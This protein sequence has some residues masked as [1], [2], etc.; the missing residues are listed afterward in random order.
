MTREFGPI[1]GYG[2]D[3]FKKEDHYHNLSLD[4]EHALFGNDLLEHAILLT[5]EDVLLRD[6]RAAHGE[7][8]QFL[9]RA[10]DP[11]GSANSFSIGFWG[12]IKW[13]PFV[14][15]LSESCCGNACFWNGLRIAQIWNGLRVA[16]PAVS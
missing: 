10:T 8:P 4:A 2:W 7:M 11:F 15:I 3:V 14:Q 1:R 6:C 12:T 5:T 13:R 9:Q 16:P